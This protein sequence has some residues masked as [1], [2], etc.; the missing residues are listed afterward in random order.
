[1]RFDYGA[2]NWKS[3]AHAVLL[4]REETVEQARKVVGIDTGPAV[5]EDAG[6]PPIVRQLSLNRNLALGAA[7][8]HH[9]LHCI[10]R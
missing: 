3:H 1:M 5:L 6:N 10:D 8:L 2:A 7:R 9:G 4:G